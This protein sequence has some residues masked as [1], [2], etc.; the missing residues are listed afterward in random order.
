MWSAIGVVRARG[1][2]SHYRLESDDVLIDVDLGPEGVPVWCRLG[3]AAGG[4]AMGVWRI[5]AVGTEVA[6]L[7]PRGDL[8]CDPMIVA[9]LS[10]GEVHADLDA[11]T[12]LIV[13]T[14]R[15]SIKSTDGEVII[16]DGTKG[17]ARLDDTVAAVESML[18]WMGTITTKFNAAIAPMASAPGTLTTPTGFGKID[19]SSSKVKIG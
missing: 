18:T 14:E 2:E 7:I 11:D 1:A 9:V 10:S 3:G 8:Q 17:A 12:L 13:N 4:A 19:S 15:V 5:P 6:I 16:Q